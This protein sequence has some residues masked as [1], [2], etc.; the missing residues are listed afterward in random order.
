TVE[1]HL[2]NA[3]SKLGVGTRAAAAAAALR[4]GLI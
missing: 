4:R 1:W 2:T 3:F